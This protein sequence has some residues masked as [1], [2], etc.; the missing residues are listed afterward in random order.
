L[1]SGPNIGILILVVS[2]YRNST[3][4]AILAEDAYYRRV[5]SRSII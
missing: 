3:P 4:L 5:I 2:F 1:T